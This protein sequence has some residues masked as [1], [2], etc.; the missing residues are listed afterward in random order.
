MWPCFLAP[1]LPS[2]LSICLHLSFLS[3]SAF[4]F[5]HCY[6]Y[7]YCSL[8]TMWAQCELFV[9]L[10]GQGIIKQDVNTHAH[11]STRDAP[12]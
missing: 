1:F 11:T 8:V 2:S 5:L 6:N 4:F 12:T 7:F 3:L 10:I 9:R